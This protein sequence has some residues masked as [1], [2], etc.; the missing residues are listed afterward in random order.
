MR[1]VKNIFKKLTAFYLKTVNDSSIISKDLDPHTMYT[2]CIVNI[3][4]TRT[5]N[6]HTYLKKLDQI[7]TQFFY[8]LQISAK[9][10]EK[11]GCRTLI[12]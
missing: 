8:S 7:Q 4:S 5:R 2:L 3:S 11:S 1:T 12:G 6:E 10:A 9:S